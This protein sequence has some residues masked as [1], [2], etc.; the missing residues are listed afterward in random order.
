MEVP[1]VAVPAKYKPHGGQPRV[2]GFALRRK[3]DLL[4]LRAHL[5]GIIGRRCVL[6]LDLVVLVEMLGNPEQRHLQP[7]GPTGVIERIDDERE[8]LTRNARPEISI[9][10]VAGAALR[11]VQGGVF[12]G[13]IDTSVNGR[14]CRSG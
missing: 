1:S 10:V 7:R 6:V 12:S 9:L 4:A 14:L 13:R 5:A 2:A 8:T 3:R 11:F